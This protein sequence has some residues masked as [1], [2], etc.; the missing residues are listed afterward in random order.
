MINIQQTNYRNI[1]QETEDIILYDEIKEAHELYHQL[2]DFIEQNGYKENDPELYKKYLRLI[3]K[4]KWVALPIFNP[5]KVLGMF[6]SHF[7]D[8]PDLTNFNLWQKLKSVLLSVA[9]IE[10]RDELKNKIKNILNKQQAYLTGGRI[11]QNITP[12]VENW[13]KDYVSAVGNTPADT[14]K[15]NQYFINSEAIKNLSAEEKERVRNFFQFYEKLKWSSADIQ[16]IEETIP[17]I[18]DD[19]KG[20]IKDGVMVK[21]D[22]E[23]RKRSQLF[24]KIAQEVLSQTYKEKS[25]IKEQIL[26]DNGQNVTSA[27]KVNS[28]VQSYQESLSEDQKM[29][30]LQ[31]N[32]AKQSDIVLPA[33]NNELMQLKALATKYPVGSLERRAVEEEIRKITN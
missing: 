6:E 28:E 4:L 29:N 19:F 22:P 20:F 7:A 25:N 1:A 33:E 3:A 5:E 2:G 21:I 26:R 8:L 31:N 30:N 24:Q 10:D 17:V 14:A 11:K 18:A 27:L 13:I 12:T 16:G 9:F 23:R 32:I 15:Q